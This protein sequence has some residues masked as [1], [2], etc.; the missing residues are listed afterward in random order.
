MVFSLFDGF[1]AP[2]DQPSTLPCGSATGN[3]EAMRF[4]SFFQSK[5]REGITGHDA[6]SMRAALTFFTAR[7]FHYYFPVFASYGLGDPD[8]LEDLL[9]T[10]QAESGGLSWRID[11]WGSREIMA[12]LRFLD[13]IYERDLSLAADGFSTDASLLA[14]QFRKVCDEL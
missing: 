13:Y 5:R 10:L 12:T 8:I 6:L 7:S 2:E 14:T 1:V 9:G 4:A 3:P 11:Q